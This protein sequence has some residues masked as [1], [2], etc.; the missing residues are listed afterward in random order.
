MKNKKLFARISA[1]AL[2]MSLLLTGCDKSG[3]ES[4]PDSSVSGSSG[5][6][7]GSLGGNS[8]PMPSFGAIISVEDIKNAYGSADSG[9]MPLY[10]IEP[11]ESFDFDFAVSWDDLSGALPHAWNAVRLDCEWY[12]TDCTNNETNCGI[13]FFL[14]EAGE[15]DL[16]RTGYTEDKLYEFD[17]AA[18]RY[19]VA[20]SE[21]EYCKSNDLCAADVNEY[22]TVLA[23]CLENPAEVIAL[24]YTGGYIPQDDIIKAVVEVYNM[25]GM[26]DKLATLGFGAS[27]SF[28]LLI[29]K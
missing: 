23:A 16:A 11:T 27:N 24:R 3:I 25:K 28:I 7:T 1:A 29:N 12:Q 26:E 9:I 17:L 19:A 4:T 2:C 5:A 13:P 22:K 15:D 21:R 20:D 8:V 10:N 6:S 14:Y 18:G